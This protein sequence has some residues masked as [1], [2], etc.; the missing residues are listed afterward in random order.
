MKGSRGW[1][2]IV[3]VVGF[4]YFIV[5]LIATA[6][7]SIQEGP[8]KPFWAAYT[9]ILTS[10]SFWASLRLSLF[11]ALAAVVIGLVIIVPAAYWAFL[12]VPRMQAWVEF[13]SILPFVVPPIV[14]VLG[15]V[16]LYGNGYGPLSARPVMLMAA[17]GVVSLPYLYR[18]VDNGLRSM[19][20]RALTEAALGLGSSWPRVMFQ[21]VLPNLRTA[22]LGGTFLVFALIMGEYAISSMLGFNTFGVYMLLTGQ[23]RAHAA[24]A[25]ALIS[26][27][28]VWLLVGV[29]QAVNRGNVTIGGSR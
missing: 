25:L 7:F 20:V 6:Q 5:P 21:V 22:L 18:S 3:A 14:L 8:A 29:M 24:A 23:T 10:P 27:A 17:Y 16:H 13:V 26:F 9:S 15:L 1:S 4:L 2:F 19:D 28:L 11:M 12:R